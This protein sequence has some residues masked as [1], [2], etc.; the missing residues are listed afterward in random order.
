MIIVLVQIEH[1]NIEYLIDMVKMTNFAVKISDIQIF[2]LYLT[3]LSQ[4]A[5][6]VPQAYN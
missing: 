4:T 5:Q 3:A 6:A 1:M 2:A